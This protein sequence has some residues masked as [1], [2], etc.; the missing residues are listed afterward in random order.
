MDDDDDDDD[1]S[2]GS[3][4]TPPAPSTPPTPSSSATPPNPT[5][6]TG[7]V[8]GGN[9]QEGYSVRLSTG[10]TGR[11]SFF[12]DDNFTALL[13][14]Y[15]SPSTP[16]VLPISFNN[17][18]STVTS[19]NGSPAI[20][21]SINQIRIDEDVSDITIKTANTTCTGSGAQITARVTP[22]SMAALTEFKDLIEGNNPLSSIAY[23]DSGVVITKVSNNTPKLQING[24]SYN[25]S[26]AF[27]I[28]QALGCMIISGQTNDDP[29]FHLFPQGNIE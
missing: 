2:G 3:S 10:A 23:G 11:L 14:I 27:S 9:D 28:D 5:S 22:G 15:D 6:T 12:S 8:T 16:I 13:T 26:L 1:Y 21:S 29:V 18:G 25:F 24:E 19:Y 4:Y 20:V 17:N 7:E